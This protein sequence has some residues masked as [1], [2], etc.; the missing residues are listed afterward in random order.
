MRALLVIWSLAPL[1]WQL[2][3]SFQPPEA[4]VA[5]AG[6][7]V[8]QWTLENYRQILS[9]D[10]PFWRYLLNSTVVGA[11]TTVLTLLI[12]VPCAYGLQ[13]Q[14]GGLRLGV[15]LALLAAALFP[16]VL[17]FLALLELARALGLANNLLA[18]SLPY[19]ALSL[20]LA[21]LVLRAAFAEMPQELEDAACLEGLNL[22]QRLR[23]VLLP[24]MTPAIASTAILVFLLSW[25]E[26]PI[27]LTWISRS[28]LLT[29]PIAMARISG[30]SLYS[31]PYGAYAAATVLGSI[32]LL[33]LVLVFQ[34]SIVAGLTQ[35][36]VKG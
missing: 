22:V 17:L 20:P 3:T 1:L 24:L 19:T 15:T 33:L 8:A 34:R 35:G 14:R 4:L 30:S 27:A 18:L 10:P 7:E 13:R 26:Y 12:G 36:A 16:I 29:L 9:G 5:P 32:P 2:Y 31:I 11:A 6:A 25:N 23:F 21:V 28:E